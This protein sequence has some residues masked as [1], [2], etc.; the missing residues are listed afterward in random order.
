MTVRRRVRGLG[1]R[2]REPADE[3]CEFAE[4]FPCRLGIEVSVESNDKLK[5]R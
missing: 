1:K 4:T 3:L 5:K 2:F